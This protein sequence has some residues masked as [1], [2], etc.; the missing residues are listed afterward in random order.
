MI[1]TRRVR[2]EDW[3]AIV[4]LSAQHSFPL[5]D[6]KNF[7]ST[8]VIVKDGKVIAFAYVKALVEAVFVPDTSSRKNIVSSL[9]LVYDKLLEDVREMNIEQVH[10]FTSNP[11][12]AEIMKEHFHF[13]DIV[14]EGL[15]LEVANG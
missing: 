3:G 2:P 6:F 8:V 10:L 11:E 9:R 14:G 12:F 15:V 1:E 5:P 4:E 7:L 13:D